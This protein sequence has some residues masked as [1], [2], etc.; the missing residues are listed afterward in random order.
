MKSV[1]RHLT[2]ICALFTLIAMNSIAQVER[3]VEYEYD[4]AG[5]VIRIIVLEQSDAPSELTITP[6]YINKG[7]KRGFVIQGSN[8]LNATVGTEEQSVSVSNVYFDRL[9][10]QATVEADADLTTGTI[11]QL[12]IANRLGVAQLPIRIAEALP[13]LSASE[14]PI[15]LSPD[16]S[17]ILTFVL[18]TPVTETT[19]FTVEVVNSETGEITTQTITLLA[20]EQVI[21]FSASAASGHVLHIII[22]EQNSDFVYAFSAY[23]SPS[24]EDYADTFPEIL[25][26]PSWFSQGV[27]VAWRDNTSLFS[28]AVG[29]SW[30]DNTS[31]FSS[32]VGVSWRDNTSLFS[33]AVSVIKGFYITE[34]Q[35]SELEQTTTELLFSGFNLSSLSDISAVPEGALTI[36]S[37]NVSEDG[38]VIS[39][40]ITFAESSLDND[41]V[42]R[43][44]HAQGTSPFIL[45]D[46]QLSSVTTQSFSPTLSGEE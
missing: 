8:L 3:R 32:A 36:N 29:V 27:G 44:S 21:Q 24:V 31:L 35:N 4:G 17:E 6:V 5:N 22:E 14:T 45:H 18:E 16:A 9:S 20:G 23:S 30:R 13:G 2:I 15:V 46:A 7:Q 39:A 26:E 41:I 12:D 34:L 33:G 40:Q 42:V 43:F 25:S 11:I 38:T 1:A 10:L 28:S 19:T 37:F